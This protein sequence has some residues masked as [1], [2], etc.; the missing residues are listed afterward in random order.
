MP[1][2]EAYLFDISKAYQIFYYLMKDKQIKLPESHKIPIAEE[3]KGKK[4]CK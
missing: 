2:E 4:Y 1:D 3:I